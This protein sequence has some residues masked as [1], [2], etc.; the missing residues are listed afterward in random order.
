MTGS[1]TSWIADK[2]ITSSPTGTCQEAQREARWTDDVVPASH[3]GRTLIVCF[4]GTG[5]K[6]DA[7]VNAT[8]LLLHPF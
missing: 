6:F 4:D 7:D 3:K 5:D 8:K 2:E 1:E